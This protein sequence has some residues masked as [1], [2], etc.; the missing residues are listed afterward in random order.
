MIKYWLKCGGEH[1]FEAWFANS[2]AFDK[3][4]EAGEIPCPVCGRGD[5]VKAP[6][7]PRIGKGKAADAAMARQMALAAATHR[8]LHEMRQTVEQNCDYVGDRFA[9][10]AR[11]IHYGETE[12]HDIYGEA[13]SDEAAALK[14]EG[15]AFSQIPWVP[16]P[17]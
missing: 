10:E 11:R 17:N 9:E 7:A 6:M 8:K 12:K 5:I 14:D 2:A 4:A 16:R 15:V 1:R 13:T 3:Q